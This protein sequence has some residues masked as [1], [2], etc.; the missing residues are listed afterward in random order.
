MLRNTPDTLAQDVRGAIAYTAAAPTLAVWALVS[1]I[2]LFSAAGAWGAPLQV[3]AHIGFFATGAVGLASM[4]A[5]ARWMSAVP[6]SAGWK[7]WRSVDL[8]VRVKRISILTLYA[9]AWITA[10]II[11]AAATG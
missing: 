5:M 1:F 4:A 9:V 7:E 8:D 11:F 10:Y 6:E 2:P 3:F